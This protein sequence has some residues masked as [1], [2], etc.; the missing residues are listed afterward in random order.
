MCMSVASMSQLIKHVEG[1]LHYRCGHC[2]KKDEGEPASGSLP[3][4]V[5]HVYALVGAGGQALTPLHSKPVRLVVDAP[6]AKWAWG[7]KLRDDERSGFDSHGATARPKAMQCG[8][9]LAL[10]AVSPARE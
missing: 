9:T 6:P 10:I 3:L 4:R 5:L 8:A 2:V 7:V 1:R